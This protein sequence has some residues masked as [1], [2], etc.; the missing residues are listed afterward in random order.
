LARARNFVVQS[1]P[2]V[3]R[4]VARVTVVVGAHRQAV[5]TSQSVG[6]SHAAYINAFLVA[7]VAGLIDTAILASTPFNPAAGTAYTERYRGNSGPVQ[8]LVSRGFRQL[9]VRY[10]GR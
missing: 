9:S 10:L 2:A 5:R 3:G 7:T 8:S 1:A 4:F 6:G